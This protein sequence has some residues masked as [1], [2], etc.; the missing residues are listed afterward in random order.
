MSFNLARD[1]D[2]IVGYIKEQKWFPYKTGA[3]KFHA[4]SGQMISE[5]TYRIHFDGTIAPYVGFLEEGTD[6][7]DI[8]HAFGWGTLKPDRKNKYTGEIPFGVG[9]RFDGKFHPG[10]HKHE[11]FIKV[12]T[13]DTI[14]DYFVKKYNGEV[15][16]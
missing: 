3:L 2:Y 10:S 8:P 14:V 7:H 16:I 12:K 13:I 1:C 4:T 5:N 9:G 6:P 15:R 11:G